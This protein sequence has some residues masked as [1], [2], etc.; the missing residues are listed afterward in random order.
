MIKKLASFFYPFVERYSSRYNGELKVVY[1]DG[2]KILNTAHA[3]YSYGSLSRIMRYAFSHINC[4]FSGNIL[5]LWLWG[6]TIVD[7]AR[8]E[9]HLKNHITAIDI[10]P[11]IIK[12]AYK[13]F[14]LEQTSNTEIIEMDAFKY[15]ESLEKIFDLVIIDLFIDNQVPEECF[16]PWFWEALLHHLEDDGCIVF[17]MMNETL[18][19]SLFKNLLRLFEELGISYTLHE[20]IDRTNQLLFVRK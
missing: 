17:N 10:D 2:K 20:N 9:F 16:K 4:S 6:G 3:N 11:V 7:L 12:L 14:S 13:E 8:R 19:A 15:I 1:V 5:I 18:S